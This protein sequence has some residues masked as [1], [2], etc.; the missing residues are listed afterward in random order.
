MNYL[1]LNCSTDVPSTT[2]YHVVAMVVNISSPIHQLF[3][4]LGWI[5]NDT[6]LQMILV[7][8]QWLLST[9]CVSSGS[10]AGIVGWNPTGGMDVCLLQ[11][12]CVSG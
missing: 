12:L 6:I 8:S 11:V 9:A 7:K 3:Q 1:S 2:D 5:K 10:L 4:L